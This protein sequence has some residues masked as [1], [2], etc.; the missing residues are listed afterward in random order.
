MIS[1]LILVLTLQVAVNPTTS[2]ADILELVDGSSLG[3]S[4]LQFEDGV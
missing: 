4:I 1:T 3:G 2:D